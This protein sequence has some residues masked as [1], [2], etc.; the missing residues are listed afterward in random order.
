MVFS[1]IT[2]RARASPGAGDGGDGDGDGGSGGG[3]AE[4][5]CGAVL[6]VTELW[7]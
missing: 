7:W 2:R 5:C 1:K 6:V 4:R 3:G